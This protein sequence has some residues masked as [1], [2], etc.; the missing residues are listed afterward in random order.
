VTAL[1][2]GVDPGRKGA[3]ALIDPDGTLIDVVDMP[4]ATGAALG[5]HLADFIDAHQ[6]HT[7]AAAWV[8][9][10]GSRPGQGHVNVFTFGAGYGVILGVLGARRIRTELLPANRWKKAMGV[11]ADK[12][13]SRD[14]AARRWPTEAHRF[15]RVRDDGRAEAA[16]L[17]EYGR[18]CGA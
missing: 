13:S 9:K 17:A 1:V 8:E 10:V 14:V 6:P 4:D 11:T 3:L 16:L 7:I 5:T 12:R 18:R 2:L 15:A